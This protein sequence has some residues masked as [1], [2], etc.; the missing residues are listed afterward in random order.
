MALRS[1]D[2]RF[3]F[4]TQGER[5]EA[6][7]TKVFLHI[8]SEGAGSAARVVWTT[9]GDDTLE[10]IKSEGSFPQ[11]KINEQWQRKFQKYDYSLFQL[12]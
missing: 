1:I 4:N 5:A 8:N 12:K 6:P 11:R 10:Q 9:A 2:P 7:L 3:A